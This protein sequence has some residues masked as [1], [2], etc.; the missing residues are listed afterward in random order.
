MRR[1][2]I[3]KQFSCVKIERKANAN[4]PQLPKLLGGKKRF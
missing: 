1:T 3:D 2:N 4:C